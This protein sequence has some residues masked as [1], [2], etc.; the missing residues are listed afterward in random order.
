MSDPPSK[1][2]SKKEVSSHNKDGDLW[3]IIEQEVYDVS[4]FQDEHP[5]GKKILLGVA[6]NDATKKFHK[7]HRQSILD[8]YKSGL[9]VGTLEEPQK[10]KSIFGFMKRS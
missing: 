5:G 2:F 10:K 3:I 8:K 9:V 6:G 7:Y 4:K 1:S